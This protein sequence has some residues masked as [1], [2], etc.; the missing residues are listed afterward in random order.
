[1][2]FDKLGTK[3]TKEKRIVKTVLFINYAALDMK[4]DQCKWSSFFCHTSWRLY[5]KVCML[6]YLLWDS[7]KKNLFKSELCTCLSMSKSGWTP[8]K[9]CLKNNIPS[10]Y[11]KHVD[12]FQDYYPS[13]LTRLNFSDKI[14]VESIFLS[15]IILVI[16]TI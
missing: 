4:L 16:E 1:M 6:L 15:C 8:M 5:I 12:C 2:F 7:T 13:D 10:N 14:S 11:H 3:F 9:Q